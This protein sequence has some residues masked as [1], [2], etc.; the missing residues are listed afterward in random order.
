MPKFILGFNAPDDDFLTEYATKEQASYESEEWCE[1]EA[2]TL[3]Q[4]KEMYEEV[5]LEWQK[6]QL[7]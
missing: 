6:S 4:A 7:K 5:F 1:V 3:E 2:D